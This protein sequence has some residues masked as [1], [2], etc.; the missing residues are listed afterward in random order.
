MLGRTTKGK[1]RAPSRPFDPHRFSEVPE[2]LAC[3]NRLCLDLT[4]REN[5]KRQRRESVQAD[6]TACVEAIVL[7]LYCAHAAD[8][9]LTVGIAMGTTRLQSDVRS[10]VSPKFMSARAFSAASNALLE[11]GLI[12]RV[13]RG[14]H[15]PASGIGE[16]GRYKAS[17]ALITIL[18][19]YGT[20]ITWIKKRP[21]AE[22]IILKNKKK[23]RIR[24]GDVPYA[25]E[26]RERL[27]IINAKL[28]QHWYDLELPDQD[29]RAHLKRDK[30]REEEAAHFDLSRRQ[31]YRVF[32]NSSWKDG[33]RFYGGWWQSIPKELRRYVTIDGKRT[34][35]ADYSGLHAA[36]LFAMAGLDVPEDPYARCF[37]SDTKGDL[38][39]IVKITFNALLNAKS[40][41][42]LSQLDN[43]DAEMTGM[44]WNDFKLHIVHCFPELREHIGTG[45]GIELQRMDADLAEKVMLRFCSMQY[46][47]LPVHDSFLV[48][49]A[50]EDE[51]SQVMQLVFK[52]IFGKEVNVKRKLSE[53]T[54]EGVGSVKTDISDILN[55]K[56]HQ[57]RLR[58]WFRGKG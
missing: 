40:V 14:Y 4:E 22:G 42:A 45:V 38:R 7:D 10:G 48:H 54:Y 3:L 29:V 50:L 9:N 36:M 52:E 27:G 41:R 8:P 44:S 37:P 46:P 58:D 20:S 53:V 30:G 32:N 43:Y 15:D 56:G 26:A 28:A 21:D 18:K 25:N 33:G 17:E 24:Y 19:S 49:H 12:Q 39:S 34:V 35:E 16:V 2:L 47:C 5:R 55:E 57:G 23:K 6:F 11:H 1:A 51:L 31:L 13:T